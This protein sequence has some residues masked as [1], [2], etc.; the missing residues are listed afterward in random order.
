MGVACSCMEEMR[1]SY[2]IL[3]RNPERKRELST[4]E[5]IILN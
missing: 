5:G 1:N 3:V 2:I 4:H